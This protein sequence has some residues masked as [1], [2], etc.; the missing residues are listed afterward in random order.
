M[1]PWALVFGPI[2]GIPLFWRMIDCSFGVVGIV[3]PYLARRCIRRTVPFDGQD[4]I[5]R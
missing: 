4:P 1:I 5:D 3:P 2:R